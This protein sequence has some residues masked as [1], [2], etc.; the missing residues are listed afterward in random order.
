MGA[1]SIS[2]S[3]QLHAIPFQIKKAAALNDL[4]RLSTGKVLGR[5]S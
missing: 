5:G 3:N 1:S 2:Y 4:N